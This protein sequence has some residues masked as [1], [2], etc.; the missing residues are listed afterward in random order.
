MK[1]WF[2]HQQ[3]KSFSKSTEETIIKELNSNI[4]LLKVFIENTDI[5]NKQNCLE[6]TKLVEDVRHF[7]HQTI[8]I[9]TM[10]VFKIIK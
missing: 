7:F 3:W 8:N 2:Y 1:L 10:L 6:F 5:K 9:I 4:N